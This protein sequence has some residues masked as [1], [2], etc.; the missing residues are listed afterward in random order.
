[1]EAPPPP[2]KLDAGSLSGVAALFSRKLPMDMLCMDTMA[3]VC[4]PAGVAAVGEGPRPEG[5]SGAVG[6]VLITG[7]DWQCCSCGGPP[8]PARC[9]DG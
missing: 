9:C 6:M 4:C 5:A 3:W 7:N 8:L 2:A 1:M